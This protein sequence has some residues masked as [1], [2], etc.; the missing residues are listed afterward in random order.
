[1]NHASE[2]KSKIG[3][4]KIILPI[5]SFLSNCSRVTI[6]YLI[7]YSIFQ[8]RLSLRQ[9]GLRRKGIRFKFQLCLPYYAK[10][11]KLWRVK[12]IIFKERYFSNSQ[13]SPSINYSYSTRN[14]TPSTF[15]LNTW[16]VPS[17]FKKQVDRSTD[18]ISF[19]WTYWY[20]AAK[21]FIIL[22]LFV[23]IYMYLRDIWSHGK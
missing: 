21:I 17:L 5:S 13:I 1:M 20:H 3:I 9:C 10:I 8:S 4:L 22:D 15:W 23:Y 11:Q 2:Q 7:N 19:W 6:G 14:S 16:F 18:D 12:V